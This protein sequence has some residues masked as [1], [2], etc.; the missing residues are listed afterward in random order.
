MK[1]S[2]VY[3]T[4]RLASLKVRFVSKLFQ[5]H[6]V[7]HTLYRNVLGTRVTKHWSFLKSAKGIIKDLINQYKS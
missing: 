4:E 2:Q 7:K 6:K 1:I 3:V 5:H